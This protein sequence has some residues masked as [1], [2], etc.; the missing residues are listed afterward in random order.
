MKKAQKGILDIAKTHEPI[1]EKLNFNEIREMAEKLG[2]KL[3]YFS[4]SSEDID[5][6]SLGDILLTISDNDR[7]IVYDENGLPMISEY[8]F[9]S[10]GSGF[11]E[12]YFSHKIYNDNSKAFKNLLRSLKREDGNIFISVNESNEKIAIP[13]EKLGNFAKQVYKTIK[14][15][16][17]VP[18]AKEEAKNYVFI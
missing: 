4:Y 3:K 15:E 11:V 18:Y 10:D 16:P 9:K 14:S 5:P 8:N 6:N 13:Y 12:I 1:N 17:L 2:Y 7:L